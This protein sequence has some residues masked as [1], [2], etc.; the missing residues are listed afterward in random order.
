MTNKEKYKTPE[1]RTKAFGNF[2]SF[3]NYEEN[4]CAAKYIHGCDEC[5][6]IYKSK[7]EGKGEAEKDNEEL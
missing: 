3:F 5:P 1:E 4:Y 6:D 2:C 7:C